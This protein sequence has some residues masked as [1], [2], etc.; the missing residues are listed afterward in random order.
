MPFGGLRSAQDDKEGTFPLLS[1][2]AQKGI[3]PFMGES[4][5]PVSYC[6]VP[7]A[8]RLLAA[9]PLRGRWIPASHASRKTNEVDL[10]PCF[11]GVEAAA[12]RYATS[13]V[14]FGDTFPS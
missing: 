8:P 7:G 12:Y 6:L 1:F 3:A 9:F 5:L 4:V 11:C 13:S 10:R 2:R 14:A